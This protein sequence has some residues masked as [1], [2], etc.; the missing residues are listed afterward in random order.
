[1]QLQNIIMQKFISIVIGVAFVLGVVTIF[2]CN[3]NSVYDQTALMVANGVLAVLSMLT[4]M[5]MNNAIRTGDA[6]AFVRTKT[7]TTMIKI[8]G[9]VMGVLGY[10]FLNKGQEG[11]KFNVFMILGFYFIYTIV[12]SIVLSKVA[13]KK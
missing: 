8:F 2:L 9:V 13:K 1:M 4:Y 3:N 7:S 11:I 12:E 6:N 5:L 10:V